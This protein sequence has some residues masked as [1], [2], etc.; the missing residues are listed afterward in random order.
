MKK[1]I[2]VT[3]LV[4]AVFFLGLSAQS[5]T[6]TVAVDGLDTLLP[7]GI[8]SYQTNFNVTGGLVTGVA[9]SADQNVVFTIPN[10]TAFWNQSGSNLV[11]L[12]DN[13]FNTSP[14]LVNGN[15]FTISYPDAISLSLNFDSF[16]LASNFSQVVPMFQNPASATFG[17]GNN[18][19]TL[20]PVPIPAAVWLL[21]SGLVGLVVLKRRKKA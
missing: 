13:G 12:A 9:F 11:V 16:L 17:A 20:S 6:L 8:I 7:D 4:L 19:L 1:S 18:L 15:L 10:V 14:L 5:A 2:M 3:T 21:G